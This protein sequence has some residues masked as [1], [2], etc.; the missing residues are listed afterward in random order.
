M[1]LLGPVDRNR[2]DCCTL[3]CLRGGGL[4]GN[5]SNSCAAVPPIDDNTD[6][7]CPN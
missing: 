2:N 4:L 3:E 5:T 1:V 6:G 7:F